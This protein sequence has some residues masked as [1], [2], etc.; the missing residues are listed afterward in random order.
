MSAVVALLVRLPARKGS[1]ALG[2]YREGAFRQ[3]PQSFRTTRALFGFVQASRTPP[4]V[5]GLCPQVFWAEPIEDLSRDLGSGTLK[6]K[7]AAPMRRGNY[8][9][10]QGAL[11]KA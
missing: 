1:S 2:E 10:P 6:L 8:R 9:V 11:S 3:E 7:S 4:V 5:N